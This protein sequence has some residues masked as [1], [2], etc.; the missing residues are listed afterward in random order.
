M[1]CDMAE[2]GFTELG[3]DSTCWCSGLVA[4]GPIVSIGLLRV[5]G[6]SQ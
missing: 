5:F 3:L 4:G 1:V 6:N 2:C